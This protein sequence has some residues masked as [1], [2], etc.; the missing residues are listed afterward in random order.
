MFTSLM[1]LLQIKRKKPPMVGKLSIALSQSVIESQR[2][3]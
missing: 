1:S 2:L 3:K